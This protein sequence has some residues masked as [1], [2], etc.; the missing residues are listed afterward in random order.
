MLVKLCVAGIM[1]RNRKFIIS[2]T[3][4]FVCFFYFG[5]L[6]EKVTKAQYITEDGEIEQFTFAMSL[7]F[8]LCVV[9]LIF[10]KV[11]TSTVW[12]AGEDSTKTSYY[13]INALTYVLAMTCTNMALQFVNY[14]TQVRVGRP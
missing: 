4:I 3:G 12:T 9:N 8:F 2:A 1:D 13:C 11:L 10:A 7:V 6:Q 5:V 14:P